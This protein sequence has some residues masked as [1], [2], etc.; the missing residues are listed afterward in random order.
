M[1]KKP[2]DNQFSELGEI[3]MKYIDAQFNLIKALLLQK[4]SNI[5]TYFFTVV[6]SIIVAASM[7]LLLTLAFSFWYGSTYGEVYEGFLISAGIY[8]FLGI[9]LYLLRKPIFSNNIIKNIG[10]ILFTKEDD[11]I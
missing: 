4:V 10:Q 1:S 5:G 11:D 7:L 9:I 6:V 8:A 2:L 3:V